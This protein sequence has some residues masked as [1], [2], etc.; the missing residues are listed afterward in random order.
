MIVQLTKH[1]ANTVVA[2]PLIFNLPAIGYAFQPALYTSHPHSPLRFFLVFEV[3][4]LMIF[5]HQN[6]VCIPWLSILD[7]CPDHFSI[8]DFTILN[9]G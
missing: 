8:L 4:A 6:S 5:L 9:T 7:M 2:K 3:A 1:I